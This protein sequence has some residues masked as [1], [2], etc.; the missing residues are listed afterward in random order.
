MQL[1]GQ[2]PAEM[3]VPVLI[4]QHMPAG[5]TSSFA[6]RLNAG[7][8]VPVVEAVDGLPIEKGV[9]YVAPGNQHMVVKE[10]MIRLLSTPK[11]H[12]V[13]PAVDL[14][15]ESVAKAYGDGTVGVI[16]TG[17]GNDGTEGLY[18]IKSTGGYSLAQNEESSVVYGMPKNAVDNGV[19]DECLGL[20]EISERLNQMSKVSK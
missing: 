19:V 12:G 1:V 11:I 9:V 8:K 20:Q 4:V 6:Q 15:F 5:F 3:S 16:L 7:S 18:H 10:N 13:R 14:L 2:F 17:M